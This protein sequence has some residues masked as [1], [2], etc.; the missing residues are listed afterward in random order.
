M[1]DRRRVGGVGGAPSARYPLGGRSEQSGR[2]RDGGPALEPGGAAT[3][4][5]R[6]G[7][8]HAAE[9]ID[10]AVHLGT[11]AEVAPFVI[12][13]QDSDATLGWLEQ[14]LAACPRGEIGL[15]IDQAPPQT[16]EE[17][18]EWLAA[19]RRLRVSHFPADTPEA[20]PQEGTWKTWKEE[21]SHHCWHEPKA[22][23]SQAI[24]RFSQ[25]A[26]IHT[27]NF[28]EKFGYSWH[29]GNSHPLA[30]PA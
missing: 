2:G 6:W 10:G 24:D 20:N 5:C 8:Q 9:N 15:W 18:E 30:H 27:V 29:E 22:A 3:S 25:T 11:G 13:W 19:H 16:S 4:D 14:V 23:L 7:T 12:D 21:V 17:G 28:L 1:G 26:R